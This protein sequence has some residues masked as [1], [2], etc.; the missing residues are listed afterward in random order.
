MK[1]EKHTAFWIILLLLFLLLALGV[2]LL[3]I[4]ISHGPNRVYTY[5][6]VTL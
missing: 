5:G 4:G 1:K 2:Y 6:A 3:A